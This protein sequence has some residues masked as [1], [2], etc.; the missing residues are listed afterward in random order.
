VFGPIDDGLII[1]HK[2]CDNE[3]CCNPYHLLAGTH[4]DNER[5]KGDHDR[6]GFP[7]EILN[8]V[9]EYKALG[10]S[11]AQIA[12]ICSGQFGVLVTQQRVSDIIT[13]SRRSSQTNVKK[14]T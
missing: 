13:G 9:L 5:D 8:A 2:E 7:I 3:A 1:R 4:G 6:W 12:S 10:M 11:Q 14:S